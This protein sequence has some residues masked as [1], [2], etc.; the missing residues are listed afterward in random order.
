M[1]FWFA[2][3]LGSLL[4]T[5]GCARYLK[6]NEPREADTQMP[7]GFDAMSK[8]TSSAAQQ[9]WDAFF[10][11]PYLSALINEALENNQE[12]NMQLQE[13]IITQNE[14]AAAKGEYIPRLDANV[15][16]GI[17]K[18]GD[19]TS[20]GVSDETHGVAKNLPDFHFGLSASWEI[21]IWG[22]L[23][24]AAK[25]ANYRYLSSIEARN[26]IVTQIVAEIA[27]S[28]YDLLALDNQIDVLEHNIQLQQDAL[29]I[30][31]FKK[32]AGRATELGVQRFRAEVLK[33]QG[34]RAELEQE[35]VMA[36][37]RINFLVGRFPQKVAR[38]PERFKETEPHPVGT[39]LPAELLDNRPDV[40]RAEL[41]LEAAKLDTKVAKARFYPSLSLD[42]DV[43][44]ESFNARHLLDT[45]ESMLYNLAGNLTAPLLNRAAIKADYRSANARQIYAVYDYERTILMAYTEVRNQLAAIDNLDRQYDR[46]EKQVEM[47]TQSIEISNT[48]YASARADY[49]EVLMTRRDSLEAQMELID[50]KRRQLQAMVDVYQ[51]LG[52]GWRK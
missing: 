22:K 30:V 46:Q 42:A 14:I 31:K 17:E 41:Q 49:V 52:G 23:R 50:T 2:L 28:Y 32:E 11:D 19:H 38:D 5:S 15:G 34:R 37:N 33:N 27:N 35:R 10:S 51:A 29:E 13:I 16:A 3:L 47:L 24:N 45:P 26:F 20:Q 18:V 40:R 8:G 9:Q 36:E 4:A 1:R 44:Y 43:G 21:D 25:A 48:L 12:L 6:G 7:D 39:G